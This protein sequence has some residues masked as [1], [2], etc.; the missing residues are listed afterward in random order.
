MSDHIRITQIYLE[1]VAESECRIFYRTHFFSV[2]AVLFTNKQTATLFTMSEKIKD[3]DSKH[4]VPDDS[5]GLETGLRNNTHD[6]TVSHDS[7]KST[8]STPIIEKDLEL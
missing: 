3:I 7:E 4:M 1:V 6:A 5:T 2:L 8:Q